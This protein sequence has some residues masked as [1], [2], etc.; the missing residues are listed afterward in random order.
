MFVL[1]IYYVNSIG[2]PPTMIKVNVFNTQ[3]STWTT[4][5][6]AW[7]DAVYWL[8]DSSHDSSALLASVTLVQFTD[9]IILAHTHTHTHTH[10]LHTHT[11][12]HK[13]GHVSHCN[14]AQKIG[15]SQFSTSHT[16][17]YTHSLVHT[18]THT[19]SLVCTTFHIFTIPL[20]SSRSS[21]I[22]KS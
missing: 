16:H 20:S 6:W 22:S 1:Q 13:H 19:E 8:R 10:T 17:T 11:H 4:S 9:T 12:T 18:H 3:T 14:T 21:Y 5:Y 2:L 15:L 7:Q